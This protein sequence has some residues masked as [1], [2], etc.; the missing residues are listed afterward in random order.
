MPLTAICPSNE[1]V[2]G[3]AGQAGT[4]VESLRTRCAPLEVTAD[5]SGVTIGVAHDLPAYGTGTAPAFQDHCPLQGQVLV[6]ADIRTGGWLDA[7]RP[8]CAPITVGP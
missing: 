8:Q 2:V 3:Y 7:I 5:R 6:G 1:V 4:Y